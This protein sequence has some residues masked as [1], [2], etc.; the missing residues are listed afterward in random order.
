MKK[1]Q[2]SR[3]LI[4]W[5]MITANQLIAVLVFLIILILGCSKSTDDMPT[6]GQKDFKIQ[7]DKV[8]TLPSTLN[9]CSGVEYSNGNMLWGLNDK[10]NASD[11]YAIDSNGV[12]THSIVLAG[13]ENIDFEDLAR[14]EMGTL[15]V[16]DFGNNDNDRQNL[17]IHKILNPE[18][19]STPYEPEAIQFSYEDQLAFPPDR[20]EYLFDVEAF[21]AYQDSLYLFVRDRTIPFQGMT[22]IYVLPTQTGNHVAKLVSTFS[23]DLDKDKGAITSAD[24]SPDGSVMGIISNERIWLF[25]N[26]NTP[27]FFLGNAQMLS[28]PAD[29]QTEGIVFV[30]NCSLYLTNEEKAENAPMLQKVFFCQ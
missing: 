26:F 13:V 18:S 25:T 24:I 6:P 15:Y 11:I 21:F 5:L 12:I 10:D 29:R 17:V 19:I 20:S 4:T 28:L 3:S 23:T 1:I 22:K 30:D 2:S 9:E 14:D 8:F 7:L 27:D 16:G